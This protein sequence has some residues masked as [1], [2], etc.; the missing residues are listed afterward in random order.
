MAEADVQPQ[1]LRRGWY[2][3][4]PS[5]HVHPGDLR[6]SRYTHTHKHTQMP[7]SMYASI[8]HQEAFKP[9]PHMCT[10]VYTQKAVL[11]AEHVTRER[12]AAVYGI[13][14]TW[15][16]GCGCGHHQAFLAVSQGCT[17]HPMYAGTIYPSRASIYLH[18][19]GSIPEGKRL[20]VR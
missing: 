19:E 18:V 3:L 11:H 6:T 1:R 2:I 14:C 17:Q 9:C 7:T 16:H 4:K 5:S 12:P 8:R 20:V 15:G 10:H 13:A